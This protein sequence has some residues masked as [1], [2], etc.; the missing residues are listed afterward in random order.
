MDYAHLLRR[1]TVRVRV[2]D[3][4]VTQD[5]RTSCR[6]DSHAFDQY[7]ELGICGNAAEHFTRG[8]ANAR[9]GE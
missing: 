7:P 1:V 5:K 9:S 6:E 3:E 8:Q 2:R 4:I